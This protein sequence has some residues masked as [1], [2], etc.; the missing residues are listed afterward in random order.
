MS[1]AA[2]FIIVRNWKQPRSTEE[3]IE[4]MWF[5]YTMGYYS[6]VKSKEIMNFIR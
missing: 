4:K 6:A 5:I 3:W 1:I 2:L